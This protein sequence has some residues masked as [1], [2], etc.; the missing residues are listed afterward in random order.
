MGDSYNPKEKIPCETCE[1]R[2]QWD[3]MVRHNCSLHQG[4]R[5][6]YHVCPFCTDKRYSTF[7]DWRNHVWGHKTCLKGRWDD[8]ILLQG[9]AA[10]LMLDQWFRFHEITGERLTGRPS[11]PRGV[12]MR[13]N[14]MLKKRP[15]WTTTL[16]RRWLEPFP[17][18]PYI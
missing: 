7:H 12:I 8:P 6:R 16:V 2:V 1:K 13:L 3:G 11:Y 9:Y 18:S 15:C 4:S 5:R 14:R 10:G 17:H